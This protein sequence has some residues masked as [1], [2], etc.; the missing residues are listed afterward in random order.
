MFSYKLDE[1]EENEGFTFSNRLLAL[2][3]LGT[4]LVF[5]GIIILSVFSPELGGSGSIGVVVFIGPFPIVF[6][7]GLD[8][9]WLI[10]IGVIIAAISL[11]V[12]LAMNNKRYRRLND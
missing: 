11:V 12:F 2:L 8:A 3:F 4:A 10:L 9:K 7:S 1:P 5:T 6:G